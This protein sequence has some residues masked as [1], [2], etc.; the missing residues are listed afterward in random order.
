MKD[1]QTK[2]IRL[3]QTEQKQLLHKLYTTTF[4]FFLPAFVLWVLGMVL[5]WFTRP[6][7]T[8]TWQDLIVSAL[9]ATAILYYGFV[10]HILSDRVRR[11]TWLKHL[12]VAV[13]VMGAAFLLYTFHF[14]GATRRLA[15]FVS[16]I[17]HL[18]VEA[19]NII[20][21]ILSWIASGVTGNLAY[22]FIK[23][24]LKKQNT[25]K[26]PTRQRNK[27]AGPQQTI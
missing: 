25:R 27:K 3:D 23:R 12:L 22:D 4:L 14:S 1:V 5:G 10:V 21:N 18:E 15:Q 20:S 26:K 6:P 7:S 9:F 24:A 2:N 13:P 16:S 19:G 17:A 11:D 8:D